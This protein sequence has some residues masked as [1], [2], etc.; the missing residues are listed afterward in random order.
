MPAL[1]DKVAIVT[2]AAQGLGLAIARRFADEGAR[3]LLADLNADAVER[4]AAALGQ[5]AVV[6]DVANRADVQ[7]MVEL[8]N[9]RIGTVDVLVNNA[10]IYRNRPLLELEEQ[11]FD[12][13]MAV[14]LKSAL[15]AIQAVAP[16]MIARRSGSIVNVASVAAVLG[17]PGATSY[18]VSK[19]GLAQLTNLAAI[20][21]APHNVRVNAIGP[22][23]FATEMAQDAYADA[24]LR[25]KILPRTPLGRFGRPE[26]AAGVALFLAS[27]DS[28]YVTGKTI[29]ADG[30][31]LGLNLTL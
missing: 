18:C 26:E 15:F 19:A 4:A 28:S 30:G 13:V 1:L 31:R 3:V 16:Q 6:V 11:E 12:W 22:G 25:A 20:E 7:R 14:N 29:Y 17:S 8:A 2:G 5:A 9:E 27:D 21:L 24:A 10:G 23:T